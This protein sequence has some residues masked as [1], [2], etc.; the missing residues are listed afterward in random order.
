MSESSTPL[1][2][3]VIG[4]AKTGTTALAHLLQIQTGA[5]LLHMEPKGIKDYLG[6]LPD[7][8]N[9]ITK[10]I[11]EHFRRRYRHLNAIIHNELYAKYDKVVFIRRDIRDEMV[12]RLLYLS[13]VISHDTHSDEAWRA[14]IDAL[15]RK[16]Q[17]PGSISFRQLCETFQSIFGPN[18]WRDITN[19]HT[20]TELEFNSFISGSVRRDFTIIQ[21]EDMIDHRYGALEE[22]FGQAFSVNLNDIELGQFA[23][24]RRSGKAGGWR[25]FF[26]P[27]DV[28]DI[29]SILERKGL[30]RFDD[31]T[32]D[33]DPQLNPADLSNYV[34]RMSNRPEEIFS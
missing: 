14:W 22:Y 17:A 24:T 3:L 26:L 8:G 34:L 9:Y 4:K 19:L 1:N 32:L 18:A 7:S 11:F 16:E 29:R 33:S 13:K 12:S 23:Y 31:W 2:C 25:S 15:R 21:Y 30:N 20:D 10:I 28:E 5:S 27:Q 6:A